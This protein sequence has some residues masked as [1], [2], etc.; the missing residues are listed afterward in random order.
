MDNKTRIIY[1]P[2]YI[3][4]DKRLLTTLC[5]LYDEVM[6]FNNKS[7]E[8]ELLFLKSLEANNKADVDVHNRIQFIEEVLYLLSS[9]A[10]LGYYDLNN[11]SNYFPK[12]DNAEVNVLVEEKNNKVFIKPDKKVNKLTADLINCVQSQNLKVS[13]FCRK[14]NLYSVSNLYNIP[15]FTFGNHRLILDNKQYVDF[16][17]NNLAIKS[18]CELAL[19]EMITS[20]VEDI[21][22][23]RDI[24]KDELLEF[25]SAMLELTYTLHQSLNN[26]NNLKNINNECDILVNTK[27]RAAVYSLEHKLKTSKNRRIRDLIFTGGKIL[28]S[29]GN[30][31]SLGQSGKELI[32]NGLGFWESI[33]GISDIQKPEDRIA[34]FILNTKKYIK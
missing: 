23:A 16:L 29:G 22:Y 19:P 10:V 18:I 15:I 32:E 21:L 5:I 28:L 17:M 11:T 25:K 31:L 6:L 13:D 33:K 24:L 8:D 2:S 14:I 3:I 9:E 7:I 12:I 4:K 1:E 30:L 20:N 34:T 27:V 26:M